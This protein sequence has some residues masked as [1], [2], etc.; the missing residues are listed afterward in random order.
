MS[1]LKRFA[2]E[3]TI[4]LVTI[5]ALYAL[6]YKVSISNIFIHKQKEIEN[7][8]YE[9]ERVVKLQEFWNNKSLSKKVKELKDI[10]K[11]SKV[12]LFKRRSKNL[13]VK[14]KNLTPKELN[15]ILKIV[16]R[17]PFEIKSLKIKREKKESYSMELLCKW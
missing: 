2:N 10:V 8:I 14:Y 17:N 3:L 9:I 11:K 16:I 7:S 6:Y 1:I 13:D 4:F 15:K 5:F 12:I